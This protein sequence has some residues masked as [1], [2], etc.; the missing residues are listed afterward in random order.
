MNKPLELNLICSIC[1]KPLTGKLILK[2]FGE[3][4]EI[5]ISPCENRCRKYVETIDKTL[6]K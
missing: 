6:H 4:V 1:S 2:E 5:L 3:R